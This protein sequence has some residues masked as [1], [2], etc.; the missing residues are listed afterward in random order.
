MQ[1]LSM[2]KRLAMLLPNS[3]IRRPKVRDC[4]Q[5]GFSSNFVPMDMKT[6][7]IFLTG[8]K[9]ELSLLP[10]MTQLVIRCLDIPTRIALMPRISP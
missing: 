6:V 7:I 2:K 1:I 5:K 8:Q 9:E 3:S 10:M 4:V